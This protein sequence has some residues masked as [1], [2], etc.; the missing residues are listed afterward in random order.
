VPEKPHAA[1]LRENAILMK[2]AS[3]AIKLRRI[4][5]LADQHAENLEKLFE[6]RPDMTRSGTA[7]IMYAQAFETAMADFD[8][9][10]LDAASSG[11][12]WEQ[13]HGI[14]TKPIKLE[15]HA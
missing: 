2:V 15:N 1:L 13:E 11:M 4:G 3:A 5:Q 6:E 12:D 10:V 7:S 8:Q 9:A 14:E